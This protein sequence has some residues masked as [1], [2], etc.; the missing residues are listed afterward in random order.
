MF[1]LE[2]LVKFSHRNTP[3]SR[4]EIKQFESHGTQIGVK[5]ILY[6]GLIKLLQGSKKKFTSRIP[7]FLDEVGSIDSANMKQLIAYCKANNFLPIFASPRERSDIPMTYI[8]RR[9]KE[10]SIL[11]NQLISTERK[12]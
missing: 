1:H 4:S 5:V 11:V 8:F 12:R 6:L 7:F 9:H 10:R 3:E 2:F